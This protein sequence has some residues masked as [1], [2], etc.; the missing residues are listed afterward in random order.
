ML[1]CP[2]VGCN[3]KN[4]QKNNFHLT[5]PHVNEHISHNVEFTKEVFHWLQ[6]KLP[7]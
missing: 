2:L 4:E 3:F 7:N 5:Y 6:I 1:A